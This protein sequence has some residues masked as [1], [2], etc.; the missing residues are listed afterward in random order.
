LAHAAAENTVSATL[1]V[2]DSG[3]L[4]AEHDGADLTAALGSPDRRRVP[5][6]IEGGLELTSVT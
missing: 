2:W 3:D 6:T 5:D 4:L 1:L